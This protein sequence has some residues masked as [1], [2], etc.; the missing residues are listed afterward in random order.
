[1]MKINKFWAKLKM[2]FIGISFMSMISCL[3][4]ILN[5]TNTVKISGIIFII[6]AVLVSIGSIYSN[7]RRRLELNA[8][9]IIL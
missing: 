1:M 9:D 3:L 2:V 7:Y 5:E 8:M 6:I 4:F